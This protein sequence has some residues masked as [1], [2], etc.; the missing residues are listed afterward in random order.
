MAVN[1]DDTAAAMRNSRIRRLLLRFKESSKNLILSATRTATKT[2]LMS[3]NKTGP[4]SPC[5][6]SSFSDPNDFSASEM[7]SQRNFHN[8]SPRHSIDSMASSDSNPS[9]L[10]PDLPSDLLSS[11]ARPPNPPG[12]P[13]FV[14][15]SHTKTPSYDVGKRINSPKMS[16]IFDSGVHPSMV[17]IA[18]NI[19]T[20][21]PF[22]LAK[23]SKDIS[24]KLSTQDLHGTFQIHHHDLTEGSIVDVPQS[25]GG[26]GSFEGSSGHNSK[27]LLTSP[28]VC[29]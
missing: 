4:A 10:L 16:E 6:N 21:D 20:L 7:G 12:S 26:L 14:C 5:R 17:T 19:D 27:P 15:Q 1:Q 11:A 22:N 13:H 3:P 25:R 23:L 28:M 2:V 9:N 24:Q 8:H 18:D 29:P